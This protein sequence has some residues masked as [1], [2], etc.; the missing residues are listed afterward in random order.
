MI[1]AISPLRSAGKVPIGVPSW[2]LGESGTASLR[3]AASGR[4]IPR[5]VEQRLP[6]SVGIL[7]GMHRMG[8]HTGVLGRTLVLAFEMAHLLEAEERGFERAA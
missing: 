7:V 8:N 5:A 6:L 2:S 1:P 4:P 3:F